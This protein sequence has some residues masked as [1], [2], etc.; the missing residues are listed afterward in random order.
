[1][2]FYKFSAAVRRGRNCLAYT[3]GKCKRKEKREKHFL[4]CGERR[5]SSNPSEII[6]FWKLLGLD[7]LSQLSYQDNLSYGEDDHLSVDSRATTESRGTG[8]SKEPRMESSIADGIRRQATEGRLEVDTNQGFE[9]NDATDS[10]SPWSPKVWWIVMY[11]TQCKLSK[12]IGVQK[13]LEKK[14]SEKLVSAE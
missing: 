9:V 2:V 1:M 11:Y 6:F 3:G 7:G 10:S 12:S 5:I 4:G 14:W 13:I 8:Q